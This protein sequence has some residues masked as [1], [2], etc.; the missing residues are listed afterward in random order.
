M[1]FLRLLLNTRIFLLAFFVLPF[2]FLAQ[3]INRDS[4]VQKFN[5]A[6]LKDKVKM[7][8]DLSPV[9]LSQVYQ[10]IKDSLNEIK[11]KVYTRSNSNEAKYLFDLIEAKREFELHQYHKTVFLLEN[12]LR[13]HTKDLAD[14]A[15]AFDLL[16]TSYMKLRNYNKVFEIEEVY[17]KQKA[18]FQKICSEITLLRKVLSI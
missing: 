7:V 8:A 15:K 16:A 10:Y 14:S 3:D 5:G 13:F 17:E 18:V 2:G 6:N 12:G 9:A 4:L 1:N 11:K